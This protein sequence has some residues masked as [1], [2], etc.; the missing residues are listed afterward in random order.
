[1]HRTALALSPLMGAL[2]MLAPSQPAQ[3][4]SESQD[5]VGK[6]SVIEQTWRQFGKLLIVDLTLRNDNSFPLQ[7]V[8]VSCQIIGDPA[9]PQDSRSVTIRQ[10]VSRGS[11]VV[12]GLEFSV[13]HDKAQGGPCKVDSAE[14]IP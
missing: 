4:A 14:R 10:H 5:L 6:V 9:R 2:L 3:A 7:G 1:M 8:I 13:T 12:R 11:T